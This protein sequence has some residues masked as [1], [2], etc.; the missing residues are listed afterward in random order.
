MLLYHAAIVASL[1]F[2]GMMIA[3]IRTKDEDDKAYTYGAIAT[4]CFFLIVLAVLNLCSR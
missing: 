2:P 4:I 3:A 1:V